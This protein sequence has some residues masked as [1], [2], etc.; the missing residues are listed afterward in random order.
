MKVILPH[1]Y[2]FFS[3]GRAIYGQ[4]DIE[5]TERRGVH[6]DHTGHKVE[7]TRY[8]TEKNNGGTRRQATTRSVAALISVSSRSVVI[9]VDDYIG[10]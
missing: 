6:E 7:I 2:Q 9:S 1:F 10:R 8:V 3:G 4:R 5:Q